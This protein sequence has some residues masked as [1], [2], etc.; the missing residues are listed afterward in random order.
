MQFWSWI[1][2][3]CSHMDKW[4]NSSCLNLL[5]SATVTCYRLAVTYPSWEEFITYEQILSTLNFTQPQNFTLSPI[6]NSWLTNNISYLKCTYCDVTTKNCPL[7]GNSLLNRHTT[8]GQWHANMSVTMK[9]LLE[10]V[11]SGKHV[12]WFLIFSCIRKLVSDY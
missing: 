12:D 4:S 6:Y 7:Q 9:E 5:P 3:L 10:T 11:F 1:S 8:A 2:A